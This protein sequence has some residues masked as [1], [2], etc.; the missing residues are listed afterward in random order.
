[1]QILLPTHTYPS[2][3]S[4]LVHDQNGKQNGCQGLRYCRNNNNNEN[5][6]N[7]WIEIPYSG[8]QVAIVII[9]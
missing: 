8:H 6:E 3:K 9:G 1:M 7:E 4:I 5:N 2:I